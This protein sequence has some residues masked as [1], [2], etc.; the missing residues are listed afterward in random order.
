M[1][2]CFS[3]RFSFG[4]NVTTCIFHS[5]TSFLTL[6]CWKQSNDLNTHFRKCYRKIMNKSL[7][8]QQLR[9]R[10]KIPS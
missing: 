3:L 1:E 8:F 6:E 7:C 2:L 4:G 10:T 9:K 5:N